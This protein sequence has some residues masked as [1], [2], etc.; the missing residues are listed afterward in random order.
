MSTSHSIED[1]E[2][3]QQKPDLSLTAQAERDLDAMKFLFQGKQ[4]F[5][6]NL[7]WFNLI[8]FVFV[9]TGPKDKK[10]LPVFYIIMNRI[11]SVALQNI[12]VLI[13]IDLYYFYFFMKIKFSFF[14]SVCV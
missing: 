9:Q 2:T 14:H 7:S 6:K 11:S 10:G 12:N 13:G 8:F 4:T 3:M 5:L 1:D